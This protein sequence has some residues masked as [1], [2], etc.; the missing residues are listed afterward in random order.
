M[1]SNF[2]LPVD[3][4]KTLTANELSVFYKQFLDEKFQDHMNYS[5]LAT[6]TDML[7]I[8]SDHKLSQA[9]PV[10]WKAGRGLGM[11]LKL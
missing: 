11:R 5:R 7:L 3:N 9:L 10:R 6:L 4:V 1:D 8:L 2:V